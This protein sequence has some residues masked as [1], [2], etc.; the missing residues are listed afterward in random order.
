MVQCRVGFLF[1]KQTG[2]SGTQIRI[3]KIVLRVN[4]Q[5]AEDRVHSSSNILASGLRNFQICVDAS[6]FAGSF[7]MISKRKQNG[8][9][10]GLSRRVK[11]EKSPSLD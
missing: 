11:H 10:A 5:C 7:E 4:G 8:I 3:A 6:I 1:F 9:F 2:P